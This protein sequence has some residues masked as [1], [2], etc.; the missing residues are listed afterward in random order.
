MR[1]DVL[2]IALGNHWVSCLRHAAGWGIRNMSPQDPGRRRGLPVRVLGHILPCGT[3]YDSQ[4]QECTVMCRSGPQ[5]KVQRTQGKAQRAEP[6]VG[7]G[8]S[9]GRRQSPAACPGRQTRLPL[10]KGSK[11]REQGRNAPAPVQRRWASLSPPHQGGVEQSAPT[12]TTCTPHLGPSSAFL[13][14]ASRSASHALR[15]KG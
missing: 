7:G 1:A 2:C 12:L 14:A 10:L 4:C 9:Q 11:R 13:A 5:R 3:Q 15:S 8:W 6:Q